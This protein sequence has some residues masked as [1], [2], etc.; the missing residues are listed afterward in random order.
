MAIIVIAIIYLLTLRYNTEQISHLG[1]EGTLR[2]KQIDY[3]ILLTVLI[4]IL[5]LI[6]ITSYFIFHK[7]NIISKTSEKIKLNKHMLPI[8]D[9]V[10]GLLE[11]NYTDNK[12]WFSSNTYTLLGIDRKS[13]NFTDTI[14]SLIHPEDINMVKENVL[15][16]FANQS[17]LNLQFRIKEKQGNFIWI[18]IKGACRKENNK[19][20]LTAAFLDITKN[21]E[22]ELELQM[23]KLK[24]EAAMKVRDEFLANISHE[25][26]TPLNAIV[27]YTQVLLNE[28]EN[29]YHRRNIKVI[30]DSSKH[31]LTLINDIIDISRIEL[32]ELRLTVEDTNLKDSFNYLKDVFE[33]KA[34]EKGLKL[35]CEYDESI[36][37][38]LRAD[39]TRINQ[40]ILKLLSN[41]LKFTDEGE[42]RLCIKLLNKNQHRADVLFQVSDTGIGMSKEH[43]GKIFNTFEQIDS[44]SSKKYRGAGIGLTIV[45]KLVKLMDGKIDVESIINTGSTFKV[46]LS[47][48]IVKE[49]LHNNDTIEK[50]LFVLNTKIEPKDIRVLVAEDNVVNQMLIYDLLSMLKI[51]NIDIACNGYEALEYFKNNT[52][53]ILIT[54]IQMP[55]MNGIEVTKEIR[56][57]EEYKDFPIIALTANVMNEQLDEYYSAGIND[58]I[59]KPLEVEEFIQ[60]LNSYL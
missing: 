8:K 10:D 52:Y 45:K 59:A 1:L 15:E 2:V 54:D 19:I 12:W 23:E 60:M 6:L 53:D 44:S 51:D 58:Y 33:P 40:I 47:F 55:E 50:D 7:D 48:D 18:K 39:E 49:T 43:F 42:V 27:G 35:I 31:L 20:Y 13:K 41:A 56:S 29:K 36:P 57:K 11:F 5:L 26:R 34:E 38:L 16:A 24:A 28:V 21:K 30:K 9:I 32:G 46:Y 22:N 25:I 3:S 4:I 17:D 37:S 14:A